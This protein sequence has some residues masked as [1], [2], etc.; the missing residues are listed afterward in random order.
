MCIF[1][2]TKLPVLSGA[3]GFCT[4]LV[5]LFRLPEVEAL[6]VSSG[7]LFPT[8]VPDKYRCSKGCLN[9]VPSRAQNGRLQRFVW[10]LVAG[11]CF[12]ID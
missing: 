12:R 9:D 10:F 2:M 11:H 8:K 4:V 6:K 7:S 5:P 1:A 3:R